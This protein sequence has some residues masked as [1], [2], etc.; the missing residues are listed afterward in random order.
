MATSVRASATVV[1]R[2][3]A[4]GVVNRVERV[5][6]GVAVKT[7]G[8]MLEAAVVVP[9]ATVVELVASWAVQAVGEG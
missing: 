5:E 1:A 6:M 4:R 3:V 7:E 2:E 9:A 8:E